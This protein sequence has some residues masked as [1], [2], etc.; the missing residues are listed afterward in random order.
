MQE[1]RIVANDA[2]MQMWLFKGDL[3][4]MWIVAQTRTA[5]KLGAIRG[6]A[7]EICNK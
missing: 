6:V 5:F 1:Q 2:D 3:Y 4:Y 7:S